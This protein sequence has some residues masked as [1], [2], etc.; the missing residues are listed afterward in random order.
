MKSFPVRLD[1]D[2]AF[3]RDS[4]ES[5]PVFLEARGQK[6]LLRLQENLVFPVVDLVHVLGTAFNRHETRAAFGREDSFG[7]G[8]R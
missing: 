6:K 2:I 8:G 5:I 3:L 7:T 1:A 4:G